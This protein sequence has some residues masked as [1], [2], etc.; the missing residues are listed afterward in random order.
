MIEVKF[1]GACQNCPFISVE[2]KTDHIYGDNKII[3]ANT[4]ITCNHMDICRRVSDYERS[5]SNEHVKKEKKS[6]G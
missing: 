3:I 2:S 4:V 1:F 6:P 5:N